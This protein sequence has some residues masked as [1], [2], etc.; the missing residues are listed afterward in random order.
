MAFGLGENPKLNPD[1][2]NQPQ[3]GHEA[4]CF[5]YINISLYL[6]HIFPLETQL[7]KFNITSPL[8]HIFLIS[9]KP[10]ALK[11]V[12][13]VLWNKHGFWLI[14]VQAL[15]WI[16]L[17]RI[18]GTDRF[19]MLLSK[20]DQR[21]E[22]AFVHIRTESSEKWR[23]GGERR[24]VLF[25]ELIFRKTKACLSR[26]ATHSP[27]LSLHKIFVS[28]FVSASVS[29][30]PAVCG[31]HHLPAPVSYQARA[32]LSMTQLPLPLPTVSLNCTLIKLGLL[33]MRA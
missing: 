9:E 7:V 22:A 27:Y 2:D 6:L 29:D 19:L 20:L 26:C 5:F 33:I 28:S 3:W 14:E 32:D 15:T 30:R 17:R 23:G 24:T 18:I 11:S 31:I 1:N 21:C 10:L 4:L 16:Y 13:V 8:Q 12:I 25:V